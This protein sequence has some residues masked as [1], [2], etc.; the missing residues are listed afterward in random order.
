MHASP[1]EGNFTQESAQA[2]KPRVVEDYN[3]YVGFV[4]KSDRIVNSCGIARRTWKW[5]KQ[6]NIK[7]TDMTILNAFLIHKSC[8]GKIKHKNFREILV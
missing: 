4:D 5:S 2:I 1:V 3:A 6:R 8:G 7:L